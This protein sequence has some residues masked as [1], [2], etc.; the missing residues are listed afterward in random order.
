MEDY[1][2]QLLI[3][4]Y[5]NDHKKLLE[6]IENTGTQLLTERLQLSINKEFYLNSRWVK[7]LQKARNIYFL[8]D[9]KSMLDFSHDHNIKLIFLKGI[10]LAADVYTKVE[11]RKSNDI[12][13]LIDKKDFCRVHNYLLSLGYECEN[14]DEKDISTGIYCEK[15]I[16]DHS[17]YNRYV[18]GIKLE[19]EIHCNAIN[20]GNAF[21]DSGDYFLKHSIQKQLLGLN[22]YVLET[23]YNLV[24]LMMH[25]FKHLPVYYLSY[26]ILGIPVKI[27]LSNLNDIILLVEKYKDSIRWTLV[28]KIAKE[29]MVVNYIE[30]VAILVNKT[31]GAIFPAEFLSMLNRWNY[32]SKINIVDY[33][34]YGLGKFMWLFNYLVNSLTQLGIYD[35]LEGKLAGISDLRR[36]AICNKDNM[37]FIDNN[38]I[39]SRYFKLYLDEHLACIEAYLIAEVTRKGINVYFRVDH[40]QCCSYAGVGELFDKDG[41]EILVVKKT[42]ILHKMYT[43]Y[44]NGEE[45]GLIETSQ[46][47]NFGRKK[48]AIDTEIKYNILS[49]DDGFICDV[50]IPFSVLRIYLEEDDEFVFNIGGLI[51]NPATGRFTDNYKLFNNQGDFFQFMNISGVRFR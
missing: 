23:E 25:F 3:H 32:L 42:Y 1:I 22:P 29:M 33:E 40:K 36:L 7:I 18:E 9:I 43:I 15:I 47:D 2:S 34:R 37:P 51:S 6:T 49:S 31:F 45:Y 39:F 5:G 24:F 38:H 12:D 11:T 26:S 41:F 19:I 10:F 14:I 16:V 48:Q 35:I 30:A 21:N 17:C 28:E 13:C 46:N 27:N 4:L 44:E 8:K 50:E 20:A